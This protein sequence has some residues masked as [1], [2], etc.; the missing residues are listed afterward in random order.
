[1]TTG[2]SSARKA[3]IYDYFIRREQEAQ[4]Y[5]ERDRQE[6]TA[7]SELTAALTGLAQAVTVM[8]SQQQQ[9]AALLTELVSRQAAQD[10]A[11]RQKRREGE[12]R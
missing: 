6:L 9:T 8:M 4:D 11:P 3:P 12:G 5:R 10:E 1:M 7:P 2:I